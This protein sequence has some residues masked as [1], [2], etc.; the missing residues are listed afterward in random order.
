VQK[1]VPEQEYEL[2]PYESTFDDFDELIIQYGF[3]TLFV[4]AFPLGPFLA[5]VNNVF[6]TRIDAFK[7]CQQTRRPE[8]RG[9]YN[10]GTWYDILN[11]VSYIA[12]GTNVAL[13]AWETKKMDEWTN[14]DEAAKAYV[15]ILA[16]H[17]ILLTKFAISFFVPDE[18]QSY[19]VHIA[20][21][22]YVVNVLIKGMEEEPED[23]AAD[24]DNAAPVKRINYDWTKISDSIRMNTGHEC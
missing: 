17:L 9:A 1:S 11:I 8:P 10:I 3:V 13:V 16:E 21:Q 23:V 5:L 24:D 18:P 22:E 15:F 19:A 20:R 4:V 7:V 2:A 12:V 14:G 6:E